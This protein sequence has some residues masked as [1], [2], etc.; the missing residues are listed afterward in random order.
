MLGTSLPRSEVLDFQNQSSTLL[1]KFHQTLSRVWPC[2]APLGTASECQRLCSCMFLSFPKYEHWLRALEE[3]IACSSWCNVTYSPNLCTVPLSLCR[4]LNFSIAGSWKCGLE[5]WVIQQQ[6]ANHVATSHAKRYRVCMSACPESRTWCFNI[7]PSK[8]LDPLKM[9]N[10]ECTLQT[11]SW[12]VPTYDWEVGWLCRD[13]ATAMLLH[14]IATPASQYALPGV[15][16]GKHSF[17]KGSCSGK[18]HENERILENTFIL[19]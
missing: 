7:A 6:T 15:W 1:R 10:D 4:F 16:K 12:N 11:S 13:G 14:H 17:A 3:P 8:G 2:C 18:R 5:F 19:Q 9:I